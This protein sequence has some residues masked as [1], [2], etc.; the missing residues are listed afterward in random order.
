MKTT[1]FAFCFLCATAAF[2]QTA[3]SL[4]SQVQPAQFQEHP[5]RATERPMAQETSLLSH[6][7][8]TY[9]KGEVPLADLGSPI[10][11]TPLGDLARD[12]KKEH[13]AVRKATKIFE[14]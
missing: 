7:P 11:Y 5:L 2:G 6:S 12:A 4:S 9:E 3:S 10:Y 1:I 8:Y 13:T 14:D